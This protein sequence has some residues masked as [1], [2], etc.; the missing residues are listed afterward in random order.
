MPFGIVQPSSK[1][2]ADDR[3]SRRICP[4]VQ[5]S[6]QPWTL[7]GAFKARDA[8]QMITV[9]RGRIAT[10]FSLAGFAATRRRF[11]HPSKSAAT[12]SGSPRLILHII[13][14]FGLIA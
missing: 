13:M 7:M 3:G 2:I 9:T 4:Q 1:K 10:G 5:V 12:R 14:I 6:R 11:L 8:S